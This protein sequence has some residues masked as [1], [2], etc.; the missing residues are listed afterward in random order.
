MVWPLFSAPILGG[1]LL[2]V[3]DWRGVFVVLGFIGIGLLL[4]A[5]IFLPETLAE[6]RRQPGGFRQTVGRFGDLLHDRVFVG[7][8]LTMGFGGAALFGYIA[9]S[10]FVLQDIYGLSPQR[11]SLVFGSIAIG[12]VSMSQVNARLIGRVPLRTLLQ[13]GLMLFAL[14]GVGVLAGV[15]LDRGLLLVLI[16]LYTMMASL[17]FI[18]PNATALALNSYPQA[19]GSASSLLGLAQFAFGALAAPLVGIAGEDTA[20]PM[21]LVIA[22]STFGAFLAFTV[23]T[24]T[25]TE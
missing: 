2:K 13:R 23:L 7:Y 25:G 12:Y 5:A 10:P 19:A 21:A 9:S 1:Q 14:S 17:G 6:N 11:F 4:I 8:A 20:L 18:Y 3:T 22:F 16:P 24:R 15:L